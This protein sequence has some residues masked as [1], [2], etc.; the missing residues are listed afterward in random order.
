MVEFMHQSAASPWGT[1]PGAPTGTQGHLS[2]LSDI[3]CPRVLGKIT[4]LFIEV[5]PQG[6]DPGDL[7]VSRISY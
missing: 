1:T 6:A 2:R 3:Y 5:A 4:L 7:L